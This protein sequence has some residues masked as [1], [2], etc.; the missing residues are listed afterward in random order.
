M[1]STLQ[2]IENSSAAQVN[3]VVSYAG[4]AAAGLKEKFDIPYVLGVP[5]GQ[6]MQQAL[7]RD[8]DLA[9]K[10]KENQI[11]FVNQIYSKG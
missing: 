6:P 11:A 10:T 2:A 7:L 9:C 5:L 4:L 3:L 8:L 1:G